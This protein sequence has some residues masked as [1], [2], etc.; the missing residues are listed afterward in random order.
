MMAAAQK[1]Q[2]AP[3]KPVVLMPEGLYRWEA[4]ADRLPFG[5]ETW[6]RRRMEG[7]APQPA[8][9]DPGCTAWRGADLLAWLAN[10]KGY[11]H[12]ADD[13]PGKK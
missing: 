12:G 13:E 1:E 9:D 4:F 10:P 8:M 11:R 3:D 5:R 2:D 6:R 7:R